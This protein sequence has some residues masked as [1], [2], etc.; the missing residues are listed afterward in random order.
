MREPMSGSQIALVGGGLIAALVLA[1][2]Q[3]IPELGFVLQT[4]GVGAVIGLA[5]AYRARQRSFALETWVITA[6][7]SLFGLAVGAVIVLVDAVL[8]LR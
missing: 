4:V 5:V 6:R 3:P 1:T 2:V 7:W 8:S